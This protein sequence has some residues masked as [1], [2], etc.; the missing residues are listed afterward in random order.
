MI[1]GRKS[2][3]FVGKTLDIEQQLSAFFDCTE[4]PHHFIANTFVLSVSYTS[5]RPRNTD[6]FGCNC[7]T[8][9]TFEKLIA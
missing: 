8:S 1:Y 2:A 5:L 3:D 7:T 4:K 6:S 9:I